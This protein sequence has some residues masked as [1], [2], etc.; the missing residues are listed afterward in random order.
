[1]IYCVQSYTSCALQPSANKLSTSPP[2]ANGD[3]CGNAE[4]FFHR[5]Q[6]KSVTYPQAGFS[7]VI[8]QYSIKPLKTTVY[9]AYSRWRTPYPQKRQQTLGATST[10]LW[11]TAESPEFSVFAERS[12]TENLH[13]IDF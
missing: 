8:D 13:L 10:P 12:P 5:N 4:N 3:N 1:M 7:A 9:K 6:R 11:K 2:T